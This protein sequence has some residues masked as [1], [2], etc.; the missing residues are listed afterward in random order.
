MNYEVVMGIEIHLEL[1]TKTKMFSGAPVLTKQQPNSCVSAID[2]ALPGTLPSVN[3]EAVRMAL[4]ACSAL[5]CQI[6]DLVRF[7]RKNYYY[8]DLPKGY[9]ITQQFHPIGEKGLLEIDVDGEKF[10][11]RINRI[12]MEEDTAKQFHQVDGTYIDYNR[13]GTPLIEIVTEAD[14]RTAQQAMLYV[15]NIRSIMYYLGVS[16]CKMEEGSLRCDVNISLRPYGYQG[17]GNKVEIKNLNSIGNVKKSIEA[18]I[19]RQSKLLD[20]GET[21]TQATYRFDESSG[22]TVMMRKK[23]G[24]VDYKYFPEPNIP[25]IKLSKNFVSEAANNLPE[26]P[27]QR[28]QRYLD[29]GLNEYDSNLLINNKE[30]SDYYD[31]AIKYTKQY[32]ALCNWLSG[33]FSAYLTRENISLSKVKILPQSIAELIEM[34]NDNTISSKQAKEVFKNMSEGETPGKIIERLNLKQVTNVEEIKN[35]VDEVINS[36]PQSVI[37]YH[38]GK[39]RALGFLVGQVMKASKGQAN[40]EMASNLIKEALN[41]K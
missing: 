41:S 19:I 37:D 36:N 10:P 3:K 26:L 11:I 32:K 33:E 16:D 9:Q 27:Q 22:T 21:I 25:M 20:A 15:E 13:A 24:N 17:Y 30:L 8:S 6:E 5:G 28:K 38:Q 31:Q 7:D 1:K 18:E 14:I 35:L 39:D 4:M 23:E 2:I 40:P 29:L 34:I 12:H